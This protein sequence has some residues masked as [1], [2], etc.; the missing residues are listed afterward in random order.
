MKTPIYL[1][2]LLLLHSLL[3]TACVEVQFRNAQPEAAAN[4]LSV[5]DELRGTYLNKSGDTLIIS[6]KGFYFGKA[7]SE[8]DMSLKA[9]ELELK[10]QGDYYFFNQKNNKYWSV[11]LLKPQ[12]NGKSI[13]SSAIDATEEEQIK[14]LK[15]ITAVEEVRGED[16]EVDKYIVS[17]SAEELEQM[18]EQKVFQKFDKLKKIKGQ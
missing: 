1:G 13:I 7:G 12:N 8:L 11:V 2:F 15:N 18:I 10:K 9:N 17:P 3:M 6:E 14:K 4:L 5:P 16:G